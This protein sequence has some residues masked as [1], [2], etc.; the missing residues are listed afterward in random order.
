LGFLQEMVADTI[1]SRE[2]SDW[3][4]IVR[5]LKYRNYRLFFGGQGISLI[6]TWMQRIAVSWLVYRLTHS[7]F[8]LGLVGFAGQI[9]ALLMA[10][11]GGL[12]ADR[13][14]RMKILIITQVLSMIQALLLALLV[15]TDLISVWHIMVLSIILGI[16]NAF[17]MPTRQ[18]MV[19]EMIENRDD[20]GN[21]IALNSSIFNGARLIGPS[22]A[23][24]L[25]ATV[26]EG[27]CFLLNAV[28]F[29][30][31]IAA[32]AAMKIKPRALS[33]IANS[34]FL[35]GLREGF[36]Y[37]FGF[38]PIRSILLLLALVSVMGMQYTVLMPIFA[39][40]ILGGGPNTYGFLIATIGAGALTGAYFLASRRSAV[41]LEKWIAGATGVLGIGLIFFSLS[42]FFWLS[43]ILMIPVGFGMMVQSA[44]SNTMLQTIVDDDKRGRLMSLYSM[45]LLGMTPLGSLLAGSLAGRIGAPN[46][47][48]ISGVFCLL[49][50]IAFAKEIPQMRKLIHSIFLQKGIVGKDEKI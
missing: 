32:L 37:A 18:A 34:H 25:I 5:A 23:G 2:T 3:R 21:A 27:I 35:Q 9:P 12:L 50:S 26:G 20:L 13:M 11:L 29:G 16:I 8:L 45:A 22:L 10:P 6:G 24:I 14:S 1:T 28:S 42:R 49:G 39:K 44:S 40:D 17:D 30:A 36:V 47:I 15:L 33:E 46:T 48:M 31:V 19:V 4:F 41:G 7:P 43:L 38:M